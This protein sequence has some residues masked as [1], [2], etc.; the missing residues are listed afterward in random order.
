MN[1]RQISARWWMGAV[2]LVLVAGSV[3]ASRA[4]SLVRLSPNDAVATAANDLEATADGYRL[5]HPYHTAT[6]TLDGLEFESRD[7]GLAWVWHL[8]AVTAGDDPLVGVETGAV[9]PVN[10]SPLTVMYPRGGLVE[11]YVARSGTLEQQFHIP[12][13]LPLAG[14]DLVITGAVRSGGTF[15]ELVDGWRWR[16]A[17]GGVRLGRVHVYDAQGAV[18]PATMSVTVN[19]TRITV[20]GA[21][22]AQAA[23]PVIVDP[24]IGNDFQLSTMGPRDDPSYDALTPAVAYNSTNDQYLVVWSG[25]QDVVGEY[26]I[27]GQ[28]VVAA[29]GSQL[30]ADFRIS[31]VGPVGDPAYDAQEPDVVYNSRTNEYL[32]VWSADHFDDGDF[33]IWARRVSALT[34]APIGSMVR[35]SVMGPDVNPDYDASSPAVAYESTNNEY[36]VV[37]EGDEGTSPLVNNEFEIWGQRLNASA[38]KLGTQFRISTTAG[39][40]DADYDAGDPDVAYNSATIPHQY[41]VVW[42]ADSDN[43]GLADDELEIW[44]RRVTT[45]GGLLWGQVRISDMGGTGNAA[46]DAGDP[47]V[48]YNSTDNQY[49]VVW[50]GDD[51]T[52]GE[53]DIFGQRL[54]GATGEELGANDFFLSNVGSGPN[55]Q[56]DALNPAV[57]YDPYNN[58]YLVVWQDDELGAGEFEIWGQVV[59]APT[60]DQIGVDTRLSDMGP[61]GDA[62]YMAQIPA[63]AYSSVR[64]NQYLVVWSGDNSV[65]GEYEIWGQRYVGGYKVYLP[66]V[67]KNLD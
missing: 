18:V 24:E 59:D 56:Y 50:E 15:D 21:A 38:E 10:E 26:E 35:V 25:S 13:P 31:F 62:S 64:N 34:G 48:T 12:R 29:S 52:D 65:D 53:F 2:L 27:W 20:D 67:G 3:S 16:T 17:D 47:A 57:A 33:E 36:L 4:P 30:G 60:G 44:G 63:V 14:T 66:M 6:F 43:G 1:G 23:Y 39:L 40:G 32:V 8:T 5:R 22:L 51:A 54:D 28:R 9:R 42:E 41:L 46:Y 45:S 11:Q 37:W 19:T 61:D 58:A 7:H 49:L 55:T